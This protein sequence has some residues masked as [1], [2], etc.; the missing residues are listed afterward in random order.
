[1][2]KKERIDIILTAA[3][4]LALLLI[5]LRT[6]ESLTSILSRVIVMTLFALSFNFQYGYGG[7]ISLGH[8]LFFG[9]GS[10]ML[11]VL[12][13]KYNISLLPAI[14]LTLLTTVL[15]A[16]FVGTVCLRNYETFMFISMGICLAVGT[17]VSKWTW[18][19]GTI[20]I[21]KRVLPESMT[22]RQV[23]ILIWACTVAA[24]VLLFVLTRTPFV[25]MLKGVR[26]NEEREVFLG[27][28]VFKLR[29][30][31][32]TISGLFASFAGI[33]YAFR[34]SGAYT[35]SIDMN[36]AF[37]AV[38]MCVI[39]GAAYFSGPVIGAVII[40]LILNYVSVLTPYYEGILGLLVLLVVY[41]MRDGLISDNSPL[42]KRIQKQK[43]G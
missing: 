15:A 38:I 35:S 8:S 30:V 41:F 18:V 40:T 20:G 25:S 36:L 26:E 1:M 43:Q 28:N 5:G 34:N 22:F 13:A 17:A 39:G 16:L 11:V 37:Q 7:M 6:S 24:A 32:Y 12:M 9:F 42:F 31:A 23:F 29:L 4:Y 14:L 10:Y 27:V 19:G 33:L 21:T 3:V 2:G